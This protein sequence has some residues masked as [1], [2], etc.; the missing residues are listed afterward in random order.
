MPGTLALKDWYDAIGS[1]Q[2]WTNA[3]DPLSSLPVSEQPLTI[4]LSDD[5]LWCLDPCGATDY[6]PNCA[7]NATE[8]NLRVCGTRD[9]PKPSQ[10]WRFNE[11]TGEIVSHGSGGLVCLGWTGSSVKPGS[12]LMPAACDGRF[13]WDERF[14][15]RTVMEGPIHG[16]F[17]FDPYRNWNVRGVVQAQG[18]V[19]AVTN[20]SLPKL[21]RT[22]STW[23][24][25]LAYN[26]Y[27]VWNT[28][29][30]TVA[31][32]LSSFFTKRPTRAKCLPSSELLGPACL[33]H[34]RG[35]HDPHHR[36]AELS[37]GRL[38]RS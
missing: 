9:I 3:L 30:M 28:S 32:S 17:Y 35:E 26:D 19:V 31:L 13:K 8:I 1:N 29:I 36:Y 12:V 6:G 21:D 7:V 10:M 24:N 25:S 5:P 11:L 14:Y 34:R 16:A 33:G 2:I 38:Q 22:Q 20:E 23:P 15:K 27:T 4:V 37:F 18:V